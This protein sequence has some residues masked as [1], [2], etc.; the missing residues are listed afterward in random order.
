M[1]YVSYKH[2]IDIISKIPLK[3]NRKYKK[4]KKGVDKQKRKCYYI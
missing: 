1:Y 2:N 3:V 4:L